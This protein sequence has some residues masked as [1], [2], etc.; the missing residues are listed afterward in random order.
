[1][2]ILVHVNL[3]LEAPNMLRHKVL[4]L[5][6]LL[7][8][9]IGS[10][11]SVAQDKP[12]FTNTIEFGKDG[13]IITPEEKKL[14]LEKAEAEEEAARLERRRQIAEAK[15]K[16]QPKLTPEEE[17][18]KAER[19][20]RYAK[21]QEVRRKRAAASINL[22]TRARNN[23]VKGMMQ[24]QAGAILGEQAAQQRDANIQAQNNFGA[25]TG[26]GR[27]GYTRQ[28]IA[29]ILTEEKAKKAILEILSRSSVGCTAN[30]VGWKMHKTYASSMPFVDSEWESEAERYLNILSGE[31]RA[32]KVKNSD[33]W[34]AGQP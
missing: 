28:E 30:F 2:H 12:K 7:Q 5:I 22:E 3:S 4:I 34:K 23:A 21:L 26:T 29:K 17:Q 32:F 20:E 1:M 6:S 18:A 19:K 8:L 11:I 33:R 15:A 24:A 9:I 10:Q 16:R 27:V 31:N 25:V 14:A 13:K